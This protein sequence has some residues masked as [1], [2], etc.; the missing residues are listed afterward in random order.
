MSIYSEE[1]YSPDSLEDILR[2]CDGCTEEEIQT[3]LAEMY[4]A[5]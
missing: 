3:I 5:E 2:Y 4:G 1:I